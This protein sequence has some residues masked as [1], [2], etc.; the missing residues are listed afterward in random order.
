MCKQIRLAIHPEQLVRPTVDT[1]MAAVET[2]RRHIPVALPAPRAA[3]NVVAAAAA[4]A[5]A[6][7]RHSRTAAL[8]LP[9]SIP[10]TTVIG[11][12]TSFSVHRGADGRGSVPATAGS[13]AAAAAVSAAAAAAVSPTR[14]KDEYT[15]TYVAA[16][17]DRAA[18]RRLSPPAAAISI[19]DDT[20]KRRSV[21]VG[22]DGQSLGTVPEGSPV[23]GVGHP[24]PARSGGESKTVSTMEVAYLVAGDEP[25]LSPSLAGTSTSVSSEPP[26]SLRDNA[27]PTES[28]RDDRSTISGDN[29]DNRPRTSRRTELLNSF[30]GRGASSWTAEG[31]DD[32]GWSSGNQPF[33][34]APRPESQ[35]G[36]GVWGQVARGPPRPESEG[37]WGDTSCVCY[38]RSPARTPTSSMKS[39]RPSGAGYIAQRPVAVVTEVEAAPY[40]PSPTFLRAPELGLATGTHVYRPANR[41]WIATSGGTTWVTTTPV[42]SA[43]AGHQRMPD[44]RHHGMMAARGDRGGTVWR[45]FP[46]PIRTARRVDTIHANRPA[47]NNGEASASRSSACIGGWDNRPRC[48]AAG[49]GVGACGVEWV[50]TPSGGFNA[51]QASRCY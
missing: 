19:T 9:Q 46:T 40:G 18:S 7:S 16:G 5:A 20:A 2:T 15:K 25:P 34:G 49:Q 22:V 48:M 44:H 30:S 1:L 43:A 51:R 27:M 12:V 10:S 47:G 28:D 21:H 39:V 4:A 33:G 36:W 32:S 23:A 29:V 24:S 11:A 6:A 14:A 35:G 50:T 45:G 13:S 3:H 38:S 8:G 26:P 41:G 37:G 31:R 17:N 42:T